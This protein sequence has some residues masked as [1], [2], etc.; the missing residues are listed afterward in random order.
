MWEGGIE[1]WLAWKWAN[2]VVNGGDWEVFLGECI[3]KFPAN[4]LE[5]GG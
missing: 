3:K 5:I 2:E 1:P 4:A